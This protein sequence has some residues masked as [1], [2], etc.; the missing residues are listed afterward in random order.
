M[1]RQGDAAGIHEE[2]TG[3]HICFWLLRSH[4]CTMYACICMCA[5][6]TE[7][8]KLQFGGQTNGKL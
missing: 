1:T 8:D 5:S 6:Q 7:A 3:V 4:E 2:F